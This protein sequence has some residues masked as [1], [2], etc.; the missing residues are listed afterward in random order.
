MKNEKG[1]TLIEVVV[2][3][4]IFLM[5]AIQITSY[6]K[7]TKAINE[8]IQVE[9]TL[10]HQASAALHVLSRDI[11]LS[12]RR[13]YQK[14]EE[15]EDEPQ[16]FGGDRHEESIWPTFFIGQ[17]QKMDFTTLSHMRLYEDQKESE[18]CRLFY[19]LKKSDNNTGLFQLIRKKLTNIDERNKEKEI[20]EVLLANIKSFEIKYFD[21]NNPQKWTSEWNS[22]KNE[23]NAFPKAVQVE[24]E[25]EE[26]LPTR[27]KEKPSKKNVKFKTIVG[28]Q[29]A[30]ADP[31]SPITKSAPPEPPP[32][33]PPGPV[34]PGPVGGP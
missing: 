9:K 31:Y 15:G 12:Y 27:I 30:Q 26:E 24:F 11:R 13:P 20:E 19:E 1:L 3:T 23:S 14:L 22:E 21:E 32:P 16:F 29:L 8:D 28:L 17:K 25:L 34:P 6:I 33:A 7:N 5:V 4:A 2:A 18:L 10:Y